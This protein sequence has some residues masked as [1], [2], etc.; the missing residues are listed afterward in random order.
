MFG[1]FEFMFHQ[2]RADALPGDVWARWRGTIDGW[3][4]FPG[5]RAW[6]HGRPSPFTESFTAFVEE[7]IRAAAVDPSQEARW[8][9]FLATGT[10]PVPPDVPA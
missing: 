6:W 3:L 5:V 1:A 2:A 8:Q 10:A 7:R 9:H 4:S